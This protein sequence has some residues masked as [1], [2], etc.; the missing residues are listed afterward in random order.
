MK[1]EAKEKRKQIRAEAQAEMISRAA[2]KQASI[3][4]LDDEEEETDMI[5]IKP[6]RQRK[7]T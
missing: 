7:Q 5:K 3:P 2:A 1:A 4:K 6:K